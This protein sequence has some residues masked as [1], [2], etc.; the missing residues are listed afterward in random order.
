[1]D[2]ETS[3][4]L[5]YMRSICLPVLILL[6]LI[7]ASSKPA[8]CQVYQWTTIAGSPGIP[9]NT[10]GTNQGASFNFPTGLAQDAS[11]NLY[12][13]DSQNNTIRKLTPSGADWIV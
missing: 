6:V 3:A 8:H 7:V 11:G 9:G 1:M 13:S 5:Q 10:D 2:A 4:R 12:V